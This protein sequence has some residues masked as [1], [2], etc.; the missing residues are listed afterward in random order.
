MNRKV[1]ILQSV[2]TLRALAVIIVMLLT[3]ATA[4]ADDSG[5]CGDGV[6]YTF[7]ESTHTLTI[8]K[9]GDGTGEMDNSIFYNRNDIYTVIIESGVTSIGNNA[10]IGCTNLTSVIIGP[11]V[12]SIG[13]DAFKGCTNLTSVTIGSKVTS[14]GKGAFYECKNLTSVTIGP[15]VTSIGGNAFYD[16]SCLKNVYVLRKTPPTLVANAFNGCSESLKIYVYLESRDTYRNKW[17]SN[18][19]EIDHFGGDCGA[20]GENVI[21]VL[22]DEDGDNNEE[23]LTIAGNGAMRDY[24]KLEDRPWNNNCDKIQK[25]IIE[26]GVTSIGNNAFYCCKNL[27]SVTIPSGVTSIGDNA[28]YQC[29]GLSSI[30]IPASVT[31]IGDTP[32]ILCT[33]LSSIY[34]D[35]ANT[36]FKLSDDGVLFSK[37]DK[38]LILYPAGKTATSYTIPDGVTSIES[39]AF[40]GC[41][42]LSSVTIPASV[43]SIGVAAFG[44]CKSLS[45]I[46]I[47]FNVTSIGNSAFNGCSNLK[48]VYVLRHYDLNNN[49]N[50]T[51]LGIDVFED[52][53]EDLKIWVPR[54]ETLSKY[55]EAWSTYESKMYGFGGYWGDDLVNDG[56]NVIWNLTDEDHDGTSET[57][58]IIGTGAMNG[59]DID[60]V[61]TPWLNYRGDI[62]TVIIRPGV[63]SIGKDNFQCCESL[64]SVTI[65]SSVTSIGRSAFWGCESL[66][67]VDIPAS[68]T[69]IGYYAFTDCTSLLSINVAD[70]NPNYKSGDG[71]LFNKEGTTL[72]HY[73]AGKTATSYTIPSSVTRIEDEAF[74]ECE[75]LSSVTIPSSVTS[76]GT[77]LF[78][79]CTSLSSVTIP[80][81]VTSIGVDAFADCTNL[82]TINL[83]RYDANANP[84]ITTLGHVDVSYN[85]RETPADLVIWVP[86]EALDI[87]KAAD[88]WKSCAGKIKARGGFCGDPNVNEGKNVTW[89]LTD[90]DG[91]NNEET[92]TIAGSGDM[93]NYVSDSDAPWNNYKSSIKTVVIDNGV[94]SIGKNAFYLCQGLTSVTIPY[95]VK[96]IGGKAFYIC[97]K[98]ASV[99][100]PSSVMTIDDCAFFNTSL[101]SV[102]IPASVSLLGKDVFSSCS[103]LESITVDKDNPKYDSRDGCNA[104][105][106][107][108]GNTLILGCKNTVI[109]DGVTSIGNNAFDGCTG[110]TSITIPSSV[111]SIGNNAFDGCTGLT[112][113]TIP[114]GVTSIGQG[115]FLNCTG[116]TSVTIPASVTSIGYDAFMGCIGVSDVYC[117]GVPKTW[118]Q[119]SGDF[120]SDPNKTKTVCHVAGSKL[121]TFESKFSNVNVTFMGDGIEPNGETYLA[122]MQSYGSGTPTEGVKAFLPVSYDLSTGTVSLT[123]VKGAPKD[124]PVIYCSAKDGEA[125]PKLFFVK[126][127]PDNSDDAK[128]ID[129]DYKA[130][131]MSK[132]FVITD[133]TKTLADVISGTGVDASEAV[134]LM[135]VNSKFTTVDVSATDLDKKAKAGLLLF[136]LSKWEYMHI[137]PSNSAVATNGNANTRTIGIGNGEATSLR[138]VKSEEVKSEKFDADAWHDLQGRKIS[139]PTKKGIYIYNGKKVL[140]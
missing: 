31:N 84:K 121:A 17:S 27:S 102:N 75:N 24:S 46:I 87:Y 99:T 32:F 88:G 83:L 108:N 56:Y 6:T 37:D 109:P 51:T 62:K 86:F 18:D 104:I 95:G 120:I 85:F 114:S 136:V 14:I 30:T 55:K 67:S 132:R 43:T 111:T 110:L 91:D 13:D 138:E 57:L 98:L 1:Y 64:T 92:L 50:I 119:S 78:E 73:P 130:V 4:W 93:K 48:E 20:N 123:E 80:A 54:F 22:T 28:F 15:D 11:K 34:V 103:A 3:S 60:G 70:G 10:F 5:S 12:T 97:D 96:D 68:V 61:V 63:T 21:W 42:N 139:K 89:Y 16:C 101:T 52:T 36:Q 82:K 129:A 25:V 66:L 106:E 74:Y 45:S 65:P 112:S 8:S 79:G 29:S 140:K 116:L 81:S 134:V 90:E 113:I 94:T 122:T 23:T 107:K 126:Y 135:L 39:G 117:F 33:G 127:V 44:I 125:L 59:D 58:S 137:E 38:K 40:Y 41:E 128:A 26:P 133:G 72:I 115:T 19:I 7:V 124:Q 47:P 49:I 9:T 105:I 118:G 69:S 2:Q 77:Y 53:H 76:I 131:E 100:I 35:D 71:V